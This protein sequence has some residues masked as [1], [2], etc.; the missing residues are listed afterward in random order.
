LFPTLSATNNLPCTPRPRPV[1]PTTSAAGSVCSPN[2]DPITVCL[3][4]S[5]GLPPRST[6]IS[7]STVP[8]FTVA[9]PAATV[10]FSTL[11]TNSTA[12]LPALMVAMSQGPLMPWPAMVLATCPML[13]MTS[14]QPAFAVA[15]VPSVVGRLPTTTQPPGRIPS[16]VVRP[17]PPGHRPGS[18]DASICANTV[19]FRPGLHDR[20]PGALQVHGVVEVADKDVALDQ[21]ADGM[22]NDGYPVGVD[23]P[24]ARHGRRDRPDPVKLPDEG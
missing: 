24:V 15:L 8:M 7:R 23:V 13:L 14:R 6:R 16:A 2:P 9:P 3:T 12:T 21:A 17:T 20:G 10:P 18:V 5:G 11:L 19:C 22:A 4:S 1:G